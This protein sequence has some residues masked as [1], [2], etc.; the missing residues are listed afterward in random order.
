MFLVSLK[1]HKYSSG[2]PKFYK[3]SFL[4]EEKRFWS[5]QLIKQIQLI[6]PNWNNWP[7]QFDLRWQWIPLVW[8]H[9]T[10]HAFNIST[11]QSLYRLWRHCTCYE[12]VIPIMTSFYLLWRHYTSY[13][14]IITAITS[15]YLLWHHCTCCDVIIPAMTSLYLLWRHY[16]FYDVIIPSMPFYALIV[17]LLADWL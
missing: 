12:V 14:I 2:F 16:T 4:I 10:C 17:F 3:A 9:Y 5:R 8:R 11:M 7:V 15:L 1:Y 13:D 6:G